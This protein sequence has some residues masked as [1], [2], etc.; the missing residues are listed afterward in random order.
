MGS[1]PSCILALLQSC[2]VSEEEEG[3]L[4]GAERELGTEGS[5]TI[6]GD[7]AALA[8]PWAELA[9]AVGAGAGAGAAEEEAEE[10]GG[11]EHRH[12]RHRHAPSEKGDVGA[13]Y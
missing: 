8:E 2:L 4:L 10:A 6:E 12:H 3:Q 7:W 1:S 11:G 13:C 5:E 9:A